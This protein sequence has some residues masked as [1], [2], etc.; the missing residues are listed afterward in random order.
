[1]NDG[2][3]LVISGRVLPIFDGVHC[4]TAMPDHLTVFLAR[5]KLV[6]SAGSAP[7]DP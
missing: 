3:S 6:D 2:K 5:R 1:M 7:V 4:P